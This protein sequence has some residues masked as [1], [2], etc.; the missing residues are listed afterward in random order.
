MHS[1]LDSSAILALLHQEPGGRAVL[2]FLSNAVISSVNAAEVLRVLVRSGA[3]LPD[4]KRAFARLHLTVIAFQ[5]DDA[6]AAVE[7]AQ[8]APEL[9]LADC[10]CLA[11]ARLRKAS[12]V[13][14]ADRIWTKFDFG[15]TVKLI[16]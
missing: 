13:V 3:S 1:V 2:P 16:R 10:A 12:E 9:S 7:V 5:P 6:A 11:L 4:A 14:T 15:V 8:L